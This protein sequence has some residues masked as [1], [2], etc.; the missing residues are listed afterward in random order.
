MNQSVFYFNVLL[1]AFAAVM[2]LRSLVY[3]RADDIAIY[4]VLM[5]FSWIAASAAV[6]ANIIIQ[7]GIYVD[8]VG[9]MP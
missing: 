4:F 2:L 8:L 9:G 5:A 6:V 1:F 7:R 3:Q